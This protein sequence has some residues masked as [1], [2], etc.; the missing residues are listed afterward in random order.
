M[1]HILFNQQTVKES[2]PFKNS[3]WQNVSNEKCSH[4]I[5]S[6]CPPPS[7]R[8][9][10]ISFATL[11]RLCRWYADPCSLSYSSTMHSGI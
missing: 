9:A 8:Q 2:I 3:T 5:C 1:T 4:L 7:T 11:Q 10:R 6:N